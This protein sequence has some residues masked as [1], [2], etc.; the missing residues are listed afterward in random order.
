MLTIIGLSHAE[1]VSDCATGRVAHYD[2]APTKKA[3]AKHAAFTVVLSLVIDFH[4]DTLEDFWRIPEVQSAF[5]EG[6]VT[7]GRIER[8]AHMVSVDT[9][10]VARKAS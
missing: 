3:E 1:D 5:F 10:T 2:Q 8:N 9:R 4:S 6:L 7:L